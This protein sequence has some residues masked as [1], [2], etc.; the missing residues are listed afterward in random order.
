MKI[1]YIL[2]ILA[3]L[4]EAVAAFARAAFYVVVF[5]DV[6]ETTMVLVGIGVISVLASYAIYTRLV[7]RRA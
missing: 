4:I 2:A 3:I 1:I 6:S 5:R 7:K